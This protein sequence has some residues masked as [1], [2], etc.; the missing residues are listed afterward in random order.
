MALPPLT[1]RAAL[2]GALAALSGPA[3]A[4]Q[5]IRVLFVGNSFI[6]QHDVPALFADIA[7]QAGHRIETRLIARNGAFVVDQFKDRFDLLDQVEAHD[8]QIVVVQPHSTAGLTEDNR[9]RSFR[10]LH[11]FRFLY[12]RVV[13]MAPWPRRAGH[14][15]YSQPGMPADPQAMVDLTEQHL[16]SVLSFD[17][18]LPRAQIAPVGRAWLLG[19]GISLYAPDGYH[20][21]RTGAWLA[22]LVIAR[23][24][25]LAPDRPTPP[26]GVKSL[27][28]LVRIAATV[29]P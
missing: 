28:P 3:F 27:G 25:G 2:A 19:E 6:T 24:L 23:T 13:Y 9:S 11:D 12:R 8:P 4:A 29:A 16:A 20:A 7:G 17:L 26:P 21:T 1:R 10:R 22:A 5:P 18:S 15:L 14:A